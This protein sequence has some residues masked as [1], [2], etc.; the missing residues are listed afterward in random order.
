MAKSQIGIAI[1]NE[2]FSQVIERLNKWLEHELQSIPP[3]ETRVFSH[4]GEFQIPGRR[5]L[6]NL[7][8]EVTGI[9]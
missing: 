2:P 7:C 4:K 9:E 3:G 5:G 8:V 6:V 1:G